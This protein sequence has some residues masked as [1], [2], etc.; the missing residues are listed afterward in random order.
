M[1]EGDVNLI[2]QRIEKENFDIIAFTGETIVLE[3]MKEYLS[4]TVEL[5]DNHTLVVTNFTREATQYPYHIFGDSNGTTIALSVIDIREFSTYYEALNGQSDLLLKE[6]ILDGVTEFT[7]RLL[8]MPTIIFASLYTVFDSSLISPFDIID[9][10]EASHHVSELESGSTL[11]ISGG[12]NDISLRSDFLFTHNLI[13][14]KTDSI[15]I[16]LVQTR[17]VPSE[18]RSAISGTFIV[19]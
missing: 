18:K 16:D 13:P 8:N 15:D 3:K 1:I 19:K 10:F 4:Y 12:P 17:K 11:H 5:L 9:S 6:E 7:T 14:L 2:A